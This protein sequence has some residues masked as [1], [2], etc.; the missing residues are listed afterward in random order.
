MEVLLI[1]ILLMAGL[2]FGTLG[3][4][5]L[6]VPRVVG[7]ILL[8]MLFAP[9]LLGG[10]LGMDATAW[11][12]PMVSVA[13]GIIAYLIGGS[14]SIAQL[15]RLGWGIVGAT[16]GKVSGAFLVVLVAVGLMGQL[17]GDLPGW[18]FALVI[19]AIAPTTAPAAIVAVIHQYRA[20]GPLTTTLLGMVALDDALGIM[21]F[22]LVLA[23]VGAEGL[24]QALPAA[25][26]DIG[27][28]IVVGAVAGFLLERLS[29]RLHEHELRL[30]ALVGG[31]VLLVGLAEAWAFSALLSSMSLGFSIRYFG[32]AM[33]EREFEPVE[34]LE[35]LV[36]VLFF[37][38]AGLH[39]DPQVVVHF[40]P[41]I[42]LYFVARAIGL[43]GGA[44]LGAGLARAPAVVVRNVGLGLLPQGGVAIGLA[45]LLAGTPRFAETGELIVNIV[46]AT[47]LL[48][49]SVGSVAARF[50]LQRAGEVNQVMG[51][52]D[53]EGK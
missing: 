17:V 27:G 31:I 23:F 13:L 48:T 46:T 7:Y 28:A 10:W 24:G 18:T 41:L 29:R 34:Q 53:N 40:A 6:G 47:T 8:G 22:S 33:A 30:V 1:G 45:L 39:F 20:R 2:L 43:A 16:A 44:T 32:G 51:G 38:F 4:R 12:E 5:Y 3:S 52:P 9:D 26:W 25:A 35:E 37:T 19:A 50:G 42:L 49:E 14:A 11:T 36:F 21:I 15:K